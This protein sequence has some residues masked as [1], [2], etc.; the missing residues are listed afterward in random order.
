MKKIPY[1]CIFCNKPKGEIYLGVCEKCI[2]K[3]KE[4]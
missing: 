2:K 4:Q 3:E 1:Y